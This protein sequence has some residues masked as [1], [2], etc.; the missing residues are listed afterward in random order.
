[1]RHLLP[2]S[3]A[4]A[5]VGCGEVAPSAPYPVVF[6]AVSDPGEALANVTLTAGGVAL[7]TTNAEGRLAVELSGTEGAMVVIAASCPENHRAPLPVAPLVLRRTLDLATGAPAVLRVSVT[8]PP[9]V[10]GGV[11]IVRA[12]GAGNRGGIPVMVDGVEMGRTDRSGV[13]HI[14]LQRA[15][16]TTVSVMLATST[17]LPDVTPHN[18]AMPFTFRDNDEIF[19]FDRP[20]EDPAPPP[21]IRRGG[22]HRNT[23]PEGPRRGPPC[24]L[25]RAGCR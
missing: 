7:G 4:I 24:R 14:A 6:E 9:A 23:P 11:V 17:L 12:G 25:G 22:G 19:L 15:P 10:R 1:M 18:P 8:C 20:L 21:V 13:A 5:L 2:L 16:G 3:L